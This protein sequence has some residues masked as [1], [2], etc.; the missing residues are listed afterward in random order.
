MTEDDKEEEEEEEETDD[1]EWEIIEE[2][3]KK[4]SD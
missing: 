3:Y 1:S 4:E 2:D